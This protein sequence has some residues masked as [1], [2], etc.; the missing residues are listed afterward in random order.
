M[1]KDGGTI[2]L[3]TGGGNVAFSS[4]INATNGST[5]AENL[6]IT[7]TGGTVNTGTVI[8]GTDAIGNLTISG[9]ATDVGGVTI[10]AI[11]ADASTA[12]AAIVA[13]GEATGD[14]ASITFSGN[15]YNTS[16]TQTYIADGYAVNGTSPTFATS[17]DNITF[18]NA[19][20]GSLVLA[21]TAHLTL[22]T[23]SLIH[24]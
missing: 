21:D 20:A 8:G 10:G 2:T 3:T 7:T 15:H 9:N 16:G 4:T 23:L 14:L 5:T 17:Q 1:E 13:I 18:T 12:G 11:G 24:I 19:G 6:V 22:S